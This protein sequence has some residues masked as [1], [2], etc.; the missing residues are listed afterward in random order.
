MMMARR[1]LLALAICLA[2]VVALTAQTPAN[3]QRIISLVPAATE[4]LFAIGAGPEVVGVSSFDTYPPEVAT[5]TRV[6]ALVDPD[7]ERILTLRPTLVVVYGSQTDLVERLGRSRIP[8]FSYRHVGLPDVTATIRELGAR[9]GRV[10]PANALA[11]AIE[12]KLADVRRRVSGLPRPKTMLV[13]SREVGAL[14]GIYASGGIGFLHDLLVTAGATDV[15]A[16]VMRQNV[17]VSSEQLLARAPEVI[18]ELWPSKGWSAARETQERAAWR[19]LPAVPAVRANR[20]LMLA[21]DKL[22]IPGPRVGEVAQ[23]LADA[24][25]GTAR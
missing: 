11:S 4:M 21:D 17:Q 3:G 24:L 2:I 13:F 6:G 15:F 16:D 12:A 8:V 1:P 5:R 25:H 18:L 14:R 10:T 22:T 9:V 7:Y 20:I 19:Q 23:A